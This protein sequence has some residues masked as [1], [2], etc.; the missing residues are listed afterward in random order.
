MGAH[1]HSVS[2]AVVGPVHNI[3]LRG[4]AADLGLAEPKFEYHSEGGALTTM[5]PTIGNKFKRPEI[6]TVRPEF[7]FNRVNMKFKRGV[8]TT[9]APEHNYTGPV[10]KQ[11]WVAPN[12]HLNAP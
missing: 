8:A 2:H 9:E 11:K 1:K 5:G 10:I 12:P 4:P 6:A 3:G 7:K